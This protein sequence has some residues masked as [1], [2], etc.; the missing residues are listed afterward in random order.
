M[1]F[2]PMACSVYLCTRCL[3]WAQDRGLEGRLAD[4]A[5]LLDSEEAARATL[6]ER[7]ESV[8]VQR[9]EAWLR[10]HAGAPAPLEVD[11]LDDPALRKL[12]SRS[13]G[14]CLAS[15]PP[16]WP[17]S[18]LRRAACPRLW[19]RCAAAQQRRRAALDSSAQPV[20]RPLR[21]FRAGTGLDQLQDAPLGS[22]AMAG[23]GLSAV[24]PKR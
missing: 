23:I 6:H 19:H 12:E 24:L 11:G 8:V 1:P 18:R 22:G 13:C 16:T 3:D 4:L 14:R 15:S 5:A 10:E 9:C 20:N 17:G 2:P 21:R 7:S